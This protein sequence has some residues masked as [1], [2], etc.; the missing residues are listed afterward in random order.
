MATPRP[1]FE[2]LRRSCPVVRKTVLLIEE[3]IPSG[4]TVED[5]EELAKY[6]RPS[7]GRDTNKYRAF[8]EDAIS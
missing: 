3:K 8:I 2:F 6:I 1:I 7:L 4:A 5:A